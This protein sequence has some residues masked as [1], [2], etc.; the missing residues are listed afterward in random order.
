MPFSISKRTKC[1]VLF[2]ATAILLYVFF[3]F[4]FPLVLP[5]LLA[6]ILVNTLLPFC[7]KFT[8]KFHISQNIFCGIVLTFLYALI[9]SA[10]GFFIYKLYKQ[11]LLFSSNYKM[12]YFQACDW[13]DTTFHINVADRLPDALVALSKGTCSI[14]FSSL[15]FIFGGI[16]GL[17]ASYLLINDFEK[18]KKMIHQSHVYKKCLPILANIRTTG[19][20]YLKTQAVITTIITI[21]M[22]TGLTFIGCPYSIVFAFVIALFDAFPAVGSGI[23]LIPFALYCLFKNAY[24]NA[25]ILLILYVLNVIIREFLEPKLLGKG[26]GLSPIFVL[27]SVYVGLHLFGIAG[28]LLGPVYFTILKTQYKMCQMDL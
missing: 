28:V 18:F 16:I 7:K 19:L 21:I 12:Y 11:L 3:K 1:Y 22:A 9:L 26:A 6:W 13:V 25:I 23:I 17:V 4:A 27:F 24:T 15:D 10:T 20:A 2:I 8:G 5:F 14:V